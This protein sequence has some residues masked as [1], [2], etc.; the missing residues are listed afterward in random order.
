MFANRQDGRLVEA[1]LVPSV[2]ADQLEVTLGARRVVIDCPS[3]TT[4]SVSVERGVVCV[5][6]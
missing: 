2:S 6:V 5:C 3:A 1:R 4:R